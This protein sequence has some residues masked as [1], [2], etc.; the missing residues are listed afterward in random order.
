MKV[1]PRNADRFCQSP[2]PKMRAVLLYGPDGGLVRERALALTKSVVED[3]KDPFRIAELSA[4][5]LKD[6]PALLSDEAAAISFGGGRRVLRVV[7]PEEG[8]APQ[9]DSFL[10]DLPGDAL[11]VVEADDLP[12][13]SKLRQLFEKADAGATIACYRDEERDLGQLLRNSLKEAGFRAAPEALDYLSAH[14]GA[15]RQ[16]TRREIEKLITYKGAPEDGGGEITLDDALATIG[17]SAHLT[18]DDL[19]QAVADGNLARLER[20]LEKAFAEGG[21]AI[22]VL[23]AVSGHFMRLAAARSAL[24]AG[25]TP[26]QAIAQLRPPVF[27]KMK[28]AFARQLGL[29]SSE[30]LGQAVNRLLECE[31]ACKRTGAPAALLTS[32]ALF[33][34]TARAPRPRR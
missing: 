30:R 17:D 20:I 19:C 15:N 29:W 12:P 24:D 9:F 6:D 18:L 10:Q 4:A 16:V 31:L 25:K 33:E 11:V 34:I 32:R 5:A 28:P 2:D 23:R 1:E 3:P 22:S 14:L 21:N 26:D 7:K 8:L 27:F 13:R